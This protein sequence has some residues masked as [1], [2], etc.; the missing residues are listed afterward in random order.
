MYGRHQF[1]LI[2]YRSERKVCTFICSPPRSTKKVITQSVPTRSWHGFLLYPETPGTIT[3]LSYLGGLRRTSQHYCIEGFKK[4]LDCFPIMPK[5][6]STFSNARFS[7][8]AILFV[9]TQSW[10]E[11]WK[12]IWNVIPVEKITFSSSLEDLEE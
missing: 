4:A 3:A 10:H 2:Y 6:A 9:P 1:M 8:L 12:T 7:S 5:D 11:N